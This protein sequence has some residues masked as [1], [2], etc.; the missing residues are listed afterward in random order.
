MIGNEKGAILI[1]SVWALAILSV[2]AGGLAYRMSVELQLTDLRLDQA[3]ARFLARA[4]VWKSIHE[5]STDETRDFDSLAEAWGANEEAFRN[6]TLE[7]GAFTV[8]YGDS[9]EDQEPCYG[10]VDEE[11][12][13]NINCASEEVL[14]RVF[15]DNTEVVPAIL[16]WRDKD[17][18]SRPGGA[19]DGY[20]QNLGNPYDCKDGDFD[21]IE[22]V[23][24]V[25][26]VSPEMLAGVADLITTYG[27]GAV[28]IN[29][30]CERVLECLGLKES[31]ISAILY[32][33]RGPDGIEGTQD[34]GAF[35]ST[36]DVGADLG[37]FA[38]L[39]QDD[40]NQVEDLID[41]G[42]LS[43]SSQYF[44]IHSTG[45]TAHAEARKEITS[46]VKRQ[47]KGSPQIVFWYEG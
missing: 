38:S 17:N 11:R 20:Y 47:A 13:V 35:R 22:E 21:V 10:I 18:V 2:L 29:T 46:V 43:V 25:K 39:P 36:D 16:D 19:E 42:L 26:G 8:S 9:T 6:Q 12:R 7:D 1:T 3:R 31:V 37:R 30:A 34:D 28:N 40:I 4:G 27:G 41:G 32:Y 45:V 44:R 23:Q 33:R 5:L 15:Q 14:L 24:M